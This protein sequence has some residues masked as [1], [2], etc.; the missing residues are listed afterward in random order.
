MFKL[1]LSFKISDLL[2]VLYDI[3]HLRHPVTLIN[4]ENDFVDLFF[5]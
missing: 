4:K 2:L 1:Y 3:C 5:I